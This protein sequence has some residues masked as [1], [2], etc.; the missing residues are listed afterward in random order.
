MRQRDKDFSGSVSI[1]FQTVLTDHTEVNGN[2]AERA[3]T[4]EQVEGS[5]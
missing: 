2:I 3:I 4:L 5:S 1:L